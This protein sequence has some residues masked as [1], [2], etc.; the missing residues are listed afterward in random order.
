MIFRERELK[1][2]YAEPNSIESTIGLKWKQL[3]LQEKQLLDEVKRRMQYA[4]EQL[5]VEIDQML[6]EHQA[7]VLRDG[8]ANSEVIIFVFINLEIIIVVEQLEMIY[9][10]L[11][12]QRNV[13]ILPVNEQRK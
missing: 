5:Q 4:S 6:L 1:P 7:Q 3:E 8:K 9:D 12:Y 13:Y 2:R 11:I 10:L